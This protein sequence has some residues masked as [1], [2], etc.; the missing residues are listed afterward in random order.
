MAAAF[1]TQ[2]SVKTQPYHA[3]SMEEDKLIDCDVMIMSPVAFA[4][5]QLKAGFDAYMAEF[6]NQIGTICL[7]TKCV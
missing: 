4:S 3:Q 1:A 7:T 6:C 5:P 2:G